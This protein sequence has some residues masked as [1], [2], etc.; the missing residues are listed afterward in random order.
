[1]ENEFIGRG[2]GTIGSALICGL[3]L[4]LTNGERG[5]G[6]FIFSLFLIW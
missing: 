6:W 5:I 2:I 3:L 1:M 4:Y